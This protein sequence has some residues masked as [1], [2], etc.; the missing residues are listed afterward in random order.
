MSPGS[1]MYQFTWELLKQNS[2][3]TVR[4]RVVEIDNEKVDVFDL[5][6]F[7]QTKNLFISHSSG[8]LSDYNP[9]EMSLGSSDK[10]TY[11]YYCPDGVFRMDNG[12]GHVKEY[13]RVFSSST[14]NADLFVKAVAY[15]KSDYLSD[16]RNVFLLRSSVYQ[17]QAD[18]LTAARYRDAAQTMLNEFKQIP[19]C[20]SSSMSL[21]GYDVDLK[22][23]KLGLISSLSIASEDRGKLIEI[24]NQY[25]TLQD[26]PVFDMWDPLDSIELRR[27]S[28]DSFGLELTKNSDG[29]MK[30]HP[31]EVWST[32]LYS[33]DDFNFL[34]DFEVV[35]INGESVNPLTQIDDISDDIYL[36]V[37]FRKGATSIIRKFNRISAREAEILEI[38]ESVNF[39]SSH[40]F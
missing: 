7:V 22:L 3:E 34:N 9:R 10:V 6:G 21:M 35:A 16:L 17:E 8:S 18:H 37:T 38:L 5:K 24:T 28:S 11:R 12:S 20:K 31:S 26:F 40:L 14:D 25:D 2:V 29:Q 19:F 39:P 4:S 23:T 32:Y 13:T 36:Q 27:R 33:F 1:P 15:D 30:L